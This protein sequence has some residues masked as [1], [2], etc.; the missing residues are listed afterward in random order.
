MI[1]LSWFAISLMPGTT[2][3]SH[4]IPDDGPMQTPALILTI[5]IIVLGVGS[6]LIGVSESVS[7]WVSRHFEFDEQS[8]EQGRIR[9]RPRVR[10]R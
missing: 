6:V 10:P 8:E 4:T 3:L 7:H 5:V 2:L 1:T 9:R